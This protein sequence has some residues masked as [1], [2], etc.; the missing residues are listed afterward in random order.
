MAA[1][2]GIFCEMNR[3]RTLLACL[4]LALSSSNLGGC[5]AKGQLV[6]ADGSRRMI[7][8]DKKDGLTMVVTTGAWTGSE[9][10]DK[11][12]SVIHVL[13]D[14]QGKTPVLIAPGDF[15]LRD[16]FGFLY[17]LYDAG[18]TFRKVVPGESYVDHRSYDPGLDTPFS[19]G[20]SSDPEFARAAL[21]WG[22]LDPGTQIR[23]FLYFDRL[24]ANANRG[25][26]LWQAQTPTHQ[27]LSTL[28]FALF[29]AR[30]VQ[31]QRAVP[32]GDTAR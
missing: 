20:Y 22:V 19:E 4:F 26:L 6:A 11:T 14:N 16:R 15:Q 24:S 9:I 13:I 3:A 29:V 8:Q 17:S 18:G 5:A 10:V 2:S 32:P 12:Y 7:A 1:K 25:T 27:R 28:G 31:S 30:G 21:P 23:G